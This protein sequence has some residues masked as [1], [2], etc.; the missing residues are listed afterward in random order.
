MQRETVQ[1]SDQ[2]VHFPLLSISFA[3]DSGEV[4]AYYYYIIIIS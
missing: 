2:T 4:L 1:R 3:Y